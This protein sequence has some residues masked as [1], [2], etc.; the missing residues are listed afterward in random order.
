M[1]VGFTGTQYG[2][3]SDQYIRLR[4]WLTTNMPT[5]LHHGDCIGADSTVNEICKELDIKIVMHPPINPTKRAFCKGAT[6]TYQPKDYL[7]RNRDIVSCS[8][9]LIVVPKER[10]ERLRSGTWATMRYAQK[11]KKE[12]VLILP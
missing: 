2:I 7:V 3:T 12:L 9:V 11:L 6:F 10:I 1:I 8:E 4:S 5:H